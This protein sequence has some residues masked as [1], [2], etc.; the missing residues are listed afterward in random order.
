[1]LHELFRDHARW[2]ARQDGRLYFDIIQQWNRENP[3]LQM[4]LTVESHEWPMSDVSGTPTFYFFDH[5][6]VK[7]KVTGWPAEGRRAELV[8]AARTVGLLPP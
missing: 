1:V 5:G 6:V 8:A 3:D 7:A 2:L 4:T